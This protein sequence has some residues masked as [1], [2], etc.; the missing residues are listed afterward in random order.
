MGR[1][2]WPQNEQRKG[3]ARDGRRAAEGGG[4]IGAI[5]HAAT[6]TETVGAGVP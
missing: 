3:L 2:G 5:S 4:Q 6:L 1:H